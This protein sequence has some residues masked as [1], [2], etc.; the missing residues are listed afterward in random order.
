MTVAAPHWQKDEKGKDSF[1]ANRFVTCGNGDKTYCS[2]EAL[3]KLISISQ[4]ER[5]VD[6]RAAKIDVSLEVMRKKGELGNNRDDTV[7]TSKAGHKRWRSFCMIEAETGGRGREGD[8]NWGYTALRLN[9]KATKT[10]ARIRRS[11]DGDRERRLRQ[12][13]RNRYPP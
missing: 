13:I 6:I 9:L 2:V 3:H 10:G 8:A 7:N 11:T 4:A 12:G 5:R 1:H